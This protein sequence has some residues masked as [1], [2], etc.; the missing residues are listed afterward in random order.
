MFAVCQP[1]KRENIQLVME[2]L[3]FNCDT[4]AF[5]IQFPTSALKYGLHRVLSAEFCFFYWFISKKKK[6]IFVFTFDNKWNAI[7]FNIS[8][9]ASSSSTSSLMS[10]SHTINVVEL[11]RSCKYLSTDY[12]CLVLEW[13]YFGWFVLYLITFFHRFHLN[14]F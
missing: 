4:V 5:R 9:S 6:I 11:N 13:L 3:N 1:E 7:H 8:S 10:V 12:Y 2:I 14:V